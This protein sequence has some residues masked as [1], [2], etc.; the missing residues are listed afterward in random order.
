M[1][2]PASFQQTVPNPRSID[3]PDSIQRATIR[4]ED[5]NMR[6]GLVGEQ[7]LAEVEGEEGG[8]GEIDQNGLRTCKKLS[9]NK[10]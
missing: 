6:K 10:Q 2:K 5:M 4:N 9:K 7:R 8:G 3:G 1:G